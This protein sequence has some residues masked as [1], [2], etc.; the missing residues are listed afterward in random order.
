ML[1]ATAAAVGLSVTGCSAPSDGQVLASTVA[2]AV[3]RDIASETE[4]GDA[5]AAELVERW[6]PQE[7]VGSPP[8]S[9]TVEPLAWEGSIRGAGGATIEL[10]VDAH[11]SATTSGGVFQPWN[12]EGRAIRCFRLVWGPW[13]EAH[14]SDMACPSGPAP[15]RPTGA[16]VPPLGATERELVHDILRLH[17]DVASIE[18]EL[19]ALV[20]DARVEHEVEA[21]EGGAVVA[22]GA[23]FGGDCIVVMRDADGAVRDAAFDPVWLQPGE[24][25]CSTRLVT[26]PPQ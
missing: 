9:A 6:I 7:S 21:F 24:L 8:G 23:R 18:A 19:A 26:G 25:G 17:D 22:V 1:W 12:S 3:A 13:Y 14:I 15:A 11:V 5:T 10:R 16:V 4:P 20:L 2:A